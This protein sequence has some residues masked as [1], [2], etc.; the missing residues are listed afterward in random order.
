MTL[1][2][3]LK[4]PAGVIVSGTA[5]AANGETITVSWGSNNKTVTIANNGTWTVTYNTADIPADTTQ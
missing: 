3:L 2:T 4:K 5:I 1:S